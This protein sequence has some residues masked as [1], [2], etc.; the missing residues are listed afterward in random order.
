MSDNEEPPNL[1]SIVPTGRPGATARERARKRPDDDRPLSDEEEKFAQAVARGETWANASRLAGY[2][3]D[4]A[5]AI[6]RAQI[7]RVKERIEFLRSIMGDLHRLRREAHEEEAADKL[8][9][10][11]SIETVV[12]KLIAVADDAKDVGNHKDA[13]AALMSVAKLMGYEQPDAPTKS[14]RGNGAADEKP[15][16]GKTQPPAPISIQ[17]LN[18]LNRQLA[19][20]LGGPSEDPRPLIDA[21][22]T[23]VVEPDR[24]GR[25][26]PTI[27]SPAGLAGE[28]D[29]E[30][31]GVVA[32]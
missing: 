29:E 13:I 27:P 9:E 8:S 30:L 28:D 5:N 1:P 17:V 11:T 20:P 12:K 3:G 22:A 21:S 19:E 14:K 18:Q 6:R 2:S 31:P 26:I 10:A 23:R 7:P 16:D 15:A 24:D 32:R 25:S 4:H